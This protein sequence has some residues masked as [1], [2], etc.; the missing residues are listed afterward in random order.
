MFH[1]EETFHPIGR[2]FGQANQHIKHKARKQINLKMMVDCEKLGRKKNNPV[3][4][5]QAP[6]KP[7]KTHQILMFMSSQDCVNVY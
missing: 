5:K 4:I 3:T 6:K 1:Q 2:M 7:I